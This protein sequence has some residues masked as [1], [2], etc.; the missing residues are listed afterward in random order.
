MICDLS[1]K[2]LAYKKGYEIL[3]EK[4]MAI[5]GFSLEN[6]YFKKDTIDE[7][8]RYTANSFTNTK[9]MIADKSAVHNYKATGYDQKKSRKKSK[10]KWKYT[11]KSCK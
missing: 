4:G 10:T 11:E 7:L 6:S 8:I 5:I 2:G 1:K 3:K 9:I